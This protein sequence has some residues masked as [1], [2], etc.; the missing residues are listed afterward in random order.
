MAVPPPPRPARSPGAPIGLGVPRSRT[1]R[2]SALLAFLLHVGLIALILRVAPLRNLDYQESMGAGGSTEAGGGGGGGGAIRIV[3][4]PGLAARPEAAPVPQVP[5]PP[6]PPA[7]VE[8]VPLPAP[9]PVTLPP[10]PPDSIP[11]A[12][13]SKASGQGT[14]SGTGS[15]SGTGTGT[16]SGSGSGNGSGTGSG[17]GPGSGGG[18]GGARP[19]APRQLILPPAEIPKA[20]RGLTLEVTF[21]IGPEGRVDD[22]L[23]DPEPADRGFARKLEDVLRDYRFR[24]AR[25]STGTPVAGRF[26][27]A[28]TF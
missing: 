20:M 8:P 4:L 12:G 19:P 5:P 6:P 17:N 1:G 23:I 26:R 14:G 2:G 10:P 3:A 27:V 28:L 21:L 15:G 16:G 7:V 11:A 24:P 18:T 13:G 25:D 22:V 9:E